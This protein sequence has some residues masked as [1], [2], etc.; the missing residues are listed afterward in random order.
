MDICSMTGKWLENPSNDSLPEGH[1]WIEELEDYQFKCS[2]CGLVMFKRKFEL[3]GGWG[4]S[5]VSPV[6]PEPETTRPSLWA[7][8]LPDC[9]QDGS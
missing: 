1:N 3:G 4:I 2:D 8:Y 5:C 6:N 7:W 9:K